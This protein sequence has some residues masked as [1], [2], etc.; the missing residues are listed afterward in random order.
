MSGAAST[1]WSS[2]RWRCPGD[3]RIAAT[4]GLAV[5]LTCGSAPNARLSPDGLEAEV[6]P[7]GSAETASTATAI[8]AVAARR[9]RGRC[10][11]CGDPALLVEEFNSW[12][13]S[14]RPSGGSDGLFD[15][16]AEDRGL[17]L[18]LQRV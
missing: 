2:K 10:E 4:P 9:R 5:A 6:A 1:A 8:A 13:P 7:A 3:S 16:E 15:G 14:V 12:S 17:P 11:P 18:C